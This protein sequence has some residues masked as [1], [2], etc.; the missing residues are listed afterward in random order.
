MGTGTNQGPRC[1][2]HLGKGSSSQDILSFGGGGGMEHVS[3]TDWGT[4][5]QLQGWV[6]PKH[7][8][9]DT[10]TPQ[11]LESQPASSSAWG[12]KLAN[13]VPSQSGHW[14]FPPAHLPFGKQSLWPKYSGKKEACD[15]H[16]RTGQGL[17]VHS[18]AVAGSPVPTR[19]TGHFS[20]SPSASVNRPEGQPSFLPSLLWD[21]S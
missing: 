19:A 1:A 20:P 16:A 10:P 3:E 18:S 21:L 12:P 13:P 5:F 14:N 11:A 9:R 6:G 8:G 7:A 15:S 17:L 4:D 2:H